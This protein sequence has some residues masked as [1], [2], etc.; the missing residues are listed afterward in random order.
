[1]LVHEG[2]A[3]ARRFFTPA[4]AGSYDSVVRLATFGRDSVW[5]REIIKAVGSRSSV[6]ELACGTGVLSSMLAAAGKN[7]VGIDLS[8]EYLRAS[9][10][11]PRPLVAQGTAEILPYRDES[12]DAVASSY[13]AKYV[14]VQSVVDECWRV[15]RPGGVAVFHDFTYPTGIVR[16]LWNAH[17]AVLRRA[18]RFATSW[19]TIF[20]QLDSVIKNSDWAA[21]TTDALRSRGFRNVECKYYTAGTAAIV[22]AERP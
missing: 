21:Q 3:S 8:F 17:F 7:V 18:G 5:K 20:Q 4:N 12:F 2:H 13:L 1:M 10:R 9:R 11:K 16:S 19:R 14:E 15:L 22:S 6:L